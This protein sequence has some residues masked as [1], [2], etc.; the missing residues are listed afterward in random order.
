MKLIIFKNKFKLSLIT[1]QNFKAYLTFFELVVWLNC[2]Y[3]K[4]TFCISTGVLLPV[5]F[6]LAEDPLKLIKFFNTG[7]KFHKIRNSKK[8]VAI[9]YFLP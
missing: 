9:S 6:Q 5:M 2:F 8:E 7:Q 3:E 1:N 4:L